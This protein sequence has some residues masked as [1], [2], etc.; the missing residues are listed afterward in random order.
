MTEQQYLLWVMEEMG[1]R[2]RAQLES[3][4]VT[5]VSEEDVKAL[6]ALIDKSKS[7]QNIAQRY[8]GIQNI[9]DYLTQQDKK[10]LE[11]EAEDEMYGALGKKE[12]RRYG[13]KRFRH[14]MRKLNLGPLRYAA[15]NGSGD[16]DIP[17]FI[18]RS[19]SLLVKHE[20]ILIRLWERYVEQAIQ[21]ARNKDEALRQVDRLWHGI[22]KRFS[23]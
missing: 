11:K 4:D 6:E 10:K 14:M 9:D 8:A 16:G 18:V 22:Q 15:G 23:K 21:S 3:L 13:K 1:K 12:R 2:K 19:R 17:D 5:L 20:D 7:L